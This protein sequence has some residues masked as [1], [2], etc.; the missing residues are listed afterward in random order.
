MGVEPPKRL[1]HIVPVAARLQGEF[2]WAQPGLEDPE[3]DAPYLKVLERVQQSEVV[4]GQR[5]TGRWKRRLFERGFLDVDP[6]SSELRLPEAH[7]ARRF[8]ASENR[9]QPVGPVLVGPRE[10]I[11]YPVVERASTPSLDAKNDTLQFRA[12]RLLVAGHGDLDG[13]PRL[14]SPEG[15]RAATG[16]LV[17]ESDVAVQ[18]QGSEFIELYGPAGQVRGELPIRHVSVLPAGLLD[19]SCRE[20]IDGHEHVEQRSR[21]RRWWLWF[22][23]GAARL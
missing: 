5:L 15:W 14:G 3:V 16:G 4:V 20:L 12:D 17:S 18:E 9:P 11:A 2:C 7:Q 10:E 23:R 19:V 8:H 6:V 22:G 21:H 1:R 13:H